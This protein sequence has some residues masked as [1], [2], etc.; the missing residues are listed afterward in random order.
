MNQEQL[1]TMMLKDIESINKKSGVRETISNIANT[2]SQSA[3]LVSDV[4]E[5]SRYE[6]L[7]MKAESRE[8]LLSKY[9]EPEAN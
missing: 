2:I 6:L 5:L 8:R 1:R 7:D 9:S 3:K 4:V